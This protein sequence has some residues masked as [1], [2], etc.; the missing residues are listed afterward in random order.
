MGKESQF[1]FTLLPGE[2]L[3]GEVA[4]P[5]KPRV[6]AGNS[7]LEG[8]ATHICLRTTMGC[9]LAAGAPRGR[10]GGCELGLS[11]PTGRV[12]RLSVDHGA[13]AQPR[14][15]GQASWG[16][17]QGAELEDLLQE[18]PLPQHTLAGPGLGMILAGRFPAVFCI[19]PTVPAVAPALRCPLPACR[20]SP[21]FSKPT[22]R[23]HVQ[24]E[25]EGSAF[26]RYCRDKT[27]QIGDFPRQYGLNFKPLQLSLSRA[28]PGSRGREQRSGSRPTAASPH[29]PRNPPGPSATT[30]T[31]PH[32]HVGTSGA[33]T[34]GRW[35]P[36][37][38]LCHLTLPGLGGFAAQ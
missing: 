2:R 21:R 37:A 20:D 14:C 32:C 19:R 8:E 17:E 23:H 36:R 7:P 18:Y 28:M 9:P 3:T 1:L 27:A 25:A 6:T 33:V 4:S 10:G 11:S 30:H 31:M 24:Q 22:P 13:R 15:P 16:Q 12:W 34:Q 29:A 35:K 26:F 38:A 5:G